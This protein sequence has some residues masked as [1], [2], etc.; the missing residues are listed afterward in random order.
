[1]DRTGLQINSFSDDFAAQI[2]KATRTA[3]T[4]NIPIEVIIDKTS[5]ELFFDDG[6]TTLTA[7]YF[8]KAPFNKLSLGSTTDK[9]NLDDLTIF[10]IATPNEQK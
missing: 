2:Q 8:A 5:V 10:E 6:E 7:L 3:L 1:M 9:I 4:S